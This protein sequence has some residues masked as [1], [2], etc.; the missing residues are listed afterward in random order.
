MSATNG[1]TR[2]VRSSGRMIG[3]AVAMVFALSA[4]FSSV[5]SASTPIKSTQLSLGDSL[6]FGYSAKLFNENIPFGAPATAFENGYADDYLK[7]EKGKFMGQQ[8]VNLGCPGET[9]DSMFG[10]GPL[11]AATDPTGESP[12]GYHKLGLPLHHEYGGTKSQLESALEVLAVEAGSGTPVTK[13][14]LNIGANDQLKAIGK[15]EAEAKAAVTAKIKALIEKEIG[16]KLGKGEIT[17]EEIPAF[18]AKRTAEEAAN[19]ANKAE[20]EKL[21]KKCIE[22]SVPALFAHILTNVGTAL[23]VLREGAKFGGVNYGGAIVVQGGYD[24]YGNVFGTGELLEGSNPLAGLLNANEAPT[25]AKFGACYANPQPTFNP[26]NAKEPAKL[27]A[28]TNMANTSESN[29]KK[30]GPDIHPTPLGY[31]KLASIMK[32]ICG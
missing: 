32:H 30:N 27:Q 6:A 5:A 10:N 8:L 26:Q 2:S 1:S 19:P 31:H 18:V 14:T 9:T 24:P 11:G 7:L 15:C 20:G 4:L 28:W 29:G 13:I 17:P 23:F 21:A 22:A 25:V 16:E 3:L 12:C